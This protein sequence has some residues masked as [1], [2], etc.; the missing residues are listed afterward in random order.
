MI[1]FFDEGKVFNWKIPIIFIQKFITMKKAGL[2]FA[3]LFFLINLMHSQFQIE[4]I[5]I[6]DTGYPEEPSIM[7][8][9]DNPNRL[10]AGANIDNYYYSEDG[11]YTWTEGTLTSSAYGVWGDP[12]VIVD[13]AGDFY[14]FHLSNPASG[15]W[16]DRIVCQKSIDGGQTWNEG[17]YMGLNGTKAQD[18]EWAVVDKSNNNIYVTWTQFDEY[19]SADTAHKSDIRFSKSTDGGQTWTDAIE[20]NEIQGN[21]IDDDN[22]VEGAVPAIGPEGQIYV[23]WAGPVGIVFDKSYNQGETWLDNDIFV[24]DMPGGWAIDIP[25]ISRCNGMPVTKCDLSGGDHH[26]TIYINWSDQRNGTDDTDIWLSKST[27]E[28][29]TWTEPLRV[30]DDP[31]GKHQFFTWMDIDQTT[32]YIYIVFYDR[33]DYTDNNTDVYLAVSKD[34]GETFQNVK[35]SDSPFYPYSSV[36][37]GDYTNIIAYDGKI[38]PIWARLDNSDLSIRMS[39]ITEDNISV[40]EENFQ[41]IALEQNAPNPFAEQTYIKFKLHEP[42]EITLE[43]FNQYGQKVSVLE[44]KKVLSKGKYVY[45]FSAQA[46]NASPGIYFFRLKTQEKTLQKKMMILR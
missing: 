43:I 34:G 25:G 13:T 15:N 1:L 12:C 23:S 18:K 30:N 11:G 6:D 16:I 22:T 45:S 37:F 38:Y 36:F 17:T 39:I 14:F 7:L 41:P 21:C 19:G 32:G 29:E 44:E 5:L 26:G 27:D 4:N 24:S 46:N 3:A 9:P 40:Q 20:I 35:I 33:R 8:D 2:L 28:G 42:T 31:P 10:V